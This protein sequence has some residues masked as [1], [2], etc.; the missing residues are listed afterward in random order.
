MLPTTFLPDSKRRISRGTLFRTQSAAFCSKLSTKIG[1]GAD[2]SIAAQICSTI[3]ALAVQQPFQ[4]RPNDSM[5]RLHSHTPQKAK[6]HSWSKMFYTKLSI[7]YFGLNYRARWTDR[8]RLDVQIRTIIV[9]SWSNRL[10]FAK[11]DQPEIVKVALEC[12][13]KSHFDEGYPII[14]I[15]HWDDSMK[16]LFSE[17]KTQIVSF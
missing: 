9:K 5:T 14:E 13:K 15:K 10:M 1:G 4:N 16:A 2:V 12:Y 7:C 17:E 8:N 3:A 11:I 6:S